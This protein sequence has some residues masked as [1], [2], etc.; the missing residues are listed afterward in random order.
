MWIAV[1]N[2]P[3]DMQAS[4]DAVRTAL[5]TISGWLDQAEA[6]H[7]GQAWSK[8]APSFCTVAMLGSGTAPLCDSTRAL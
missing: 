7:Q 6:C 8:A 5:Q 1:D 4:D 2:L 3:D